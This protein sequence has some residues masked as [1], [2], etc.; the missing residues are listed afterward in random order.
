MDNS[1][2][3]FSSSDIDS[4]GDHESDGVEIGPISYKTYQEITQ[5]TGHKRQQQY[6]L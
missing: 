4:S 2:E 3:L 6:V 5:T 1:D